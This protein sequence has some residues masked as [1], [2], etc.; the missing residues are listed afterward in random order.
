MI[1]RQA[2]AACGGHRWPVV[3]KE[4]LGVL[5]EGLREREGKKKSNVKGVHVVAS[6]FNFIIFLIK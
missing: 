2:K 6:H 4:E 5:G 3:V 1:R